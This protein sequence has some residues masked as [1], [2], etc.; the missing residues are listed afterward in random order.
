MHLDD[1]RS[2]KDIQE[3]LGH[4]TLATTADIY[5]HQLFKAKE[6]MAASVGAKLTIKQTQTALKTFVS[7]H[8][9]MQ[10]QAFESWF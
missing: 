5:T 9:Y 3:W 2:L 8:V 10:S 1:G 4:A 6:A 7:L